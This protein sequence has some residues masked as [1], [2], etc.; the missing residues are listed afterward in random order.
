[1]R[2]IGVQPAPNE[3]V[4]GAYFDAY[5][6]GRDRERCDRERYIAAAVQHGRL[7][8]QDAR[9]TARLVR[10]LSDPLER[11]RRRRALREL[12]H[13]LERSPVPR[14]RVRAARPR[15]RPRGRP[16][17][18]GARAPTSDDADP[19]PAPRTRA[20]SRAWSR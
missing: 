15:R 14:L 13:W 6:R 17:G 7:R 11:Y 9:A 12:L 2:C 4:A 8:P 20:T 10:A 3:W 18:R 16:R 19:E 1:M 5:V